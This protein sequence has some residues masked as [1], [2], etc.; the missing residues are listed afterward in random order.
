LT[1]SIRLLCTHGDARLSPLAPSFPQIQEDGQSGRTID[2]LIKP[3]KQRRDQESGRVYKKRE[4]RFVVLTEKGNGHGR[5][6]ELIIGH[7][8][9]PS[10]AVADATPIIG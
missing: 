5:V 4:G 8:S 10:H 1:Q 9:C 7:Y 3:M 2:E 6:A